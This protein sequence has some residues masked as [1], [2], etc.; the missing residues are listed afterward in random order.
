MITT[1]SPISELISF[2]SRNS[3][4]SPQNKLIKEIENL[5]DLVSIKVQK[6]G[7][8]GA[9]E[10]L[11]DP[12][13]KIR[14][15]LSNEPEIIDRFHQISNHIQQRIKDQFENANNQK[16]LEHA[17]IN[18]L[19]IYGQIADAFFSKV[20][21]EDINPSISILSKT[22]YNEYK[23]FINYYLIGDEHGRQYL[24]SSL[25]LDYSMIVSD[26]VFEKKIKLN[27]DEISILTKQLKSSLETFA[28][29]SYYFKIWAPNDKDESQWI[30]NIKIRIS[31]FDSFM[32]TDHLSPTK[33]TRAIVS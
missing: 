3:I 9:F 12:I 11:V 30:R 15:G 23:S 10:H 28:V 14:F 4:S 17:F 31:L 16:E 7:V 19:N 27:E 6:K 33:V 13:F 24:S 32:P 25:L 8:Y 1:K 22:S 29:Y 2:V 26:L 5:L 21:T 18:T 20:A